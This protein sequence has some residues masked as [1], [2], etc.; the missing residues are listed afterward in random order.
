MDDGRSRKFGSRSEVL[1]V[2]DDDRNKFFSWWWIW[3]DNVV[4]FS[5]IG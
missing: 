4:E 1:A 2:G 5:A 3:R